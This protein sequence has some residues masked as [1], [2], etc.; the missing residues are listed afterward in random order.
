MHA[1]QSTR[2]NFEDKTH[3]SLIY[4]HNHSITLTVSLQALH[5]SRTT[6]HVLFVASMHTF[7]YVLF[8]PSHQNSFLPDIYIYFIFHFLIYSSVAVE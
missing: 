8:R 4:K 1:N 2:I 7:I 6:L 5:I 3:I